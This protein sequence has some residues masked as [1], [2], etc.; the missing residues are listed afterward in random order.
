MGENNEIRGSSANIPNLRT[1]TEFIYSLNKNK[2]LIQVLKLC[3]LQ[4]Q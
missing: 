1:H 2:I 4:G 3:Q